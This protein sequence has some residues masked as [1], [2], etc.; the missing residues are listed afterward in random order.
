MASWLVKLQQDA[1]KALEEADRLAAERVKEDERQEQRRKMREAILAGEDNKPEADMAN[2]T[3]V[4]PNEQKRQDKEAAKPP[5]TRQLQPSKPALPSRNGH[6]VRNQAFDEE[7]K[8]RLEQEIR[9]LES[10]LAAAST[11]YRTCQDALND[12]QHSL[13]KLQTQYQQLRISSAQERRELEMQLEQA[14]MSKAVVEDT[15]TSLTTQI[16]SLEESNR[17][18]QAALQTSQAQ[19]RR[20]EATNTKLTRDHEAYKAKAQRILQSKEQLLSERQS[21]NGVLRNTAADS[22]RD[23]DTTIDVG[24]VAKLEADLE[25]LEIYNAELLER[26]EEMDQQAK[27]DADLAGAHFRDLELALSETQSQ[28]QQSK[29]DFGLKLRELSFERDEALRQKQQL[30]GQLDAQVGVVKELEAKLAQQASVMANTSSNSR[31]ATLTDELLE[32][33]L[34]NETLKQE[35][36]GLKV[37]LDEERIKA[38]SAYKQLADRSAATPRWDDDYVVTDMQPLLRESAALDQQSMNA[39]LRNAASV[40]DT[41]SIR[42]GVFLRRYPIARLGVIIYM[43]LLHAWVMIVLLTYQPEIHGTSHSS[44][45]FHPQHP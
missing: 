7:G 19:I 34:Q 41:M 43:V 32:R 21:G 30:A 25:E 45:Q 18:L 31:I 22:D 26:I 38:A 6:L 15:D 13:Q 42:L 27:T 39:R 37:Q 9:S 29:E 3:D 4:A 35:V 1:V 10:E 5:D 24:R 40:I 36:M 23:E 33:Q 28:L 2:T 44:A 20:L 12:S 11:K 14:V 17:D 16:A 8:A